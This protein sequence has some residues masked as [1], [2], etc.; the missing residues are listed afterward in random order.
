MKRTFPRVFESFRIR[1]V[2]DYPS[3]LRDM[4]EYLAPADIETLVQTQ[5]KAIDQA[6][7]E[8]LARS[9][10]DLTKVRQG[11]EVRAQPD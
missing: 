9:N 3:R 6:K 11:G 2:D 10:L 7:A 5:A 4:L 1:P 8:A